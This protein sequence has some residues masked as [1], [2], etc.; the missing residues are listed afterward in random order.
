MNF[1]NNQ[2]VPMN[3]SG[4]WR[5]WGTNEPPQGGFGEAETPNPFAE[6]FQIAYRWK[7]FILAL[8]VLGAGVGFAWFLFTPQMYSATATLE[9]QGFNESFM[10]MNIV[11]PQAGTG[12][13]SPTVLNLQTQI[14]IL[15]SASLRR[16]VWERLERETAPMVVL[17]IGIFA[18]LRRLIGSDEKDPLQSMR[19]GLELASFNFNAR[20]VP[21]TR[22]IALNTESTNPEIAANFV[23]TLANE[24]MSQNIQFRASNAQ[25]T[26]QW[27]AGQ[28][29]ETKYRLEQAEAKLQ[30]FIRTSGLVFV[31]DQNT[32][33]DS[34]LR[35]LQGE[36]SS[37][38]SD[39]IEKQTR[40]ELL[41]N[42]PADSLPD[43][44]DDVNL[45]NAQQE[46]ARLK[47]ERQVLLT[48]LTPAHRKV[49]LL[50]AEIAA[51]EPTVRKERED[52]LRR[53]RS[54][55]EAAE[56]REKLLYNAY[57]A[58]ARAL[59]AQQDKAAQYNLLKREVENLRQSLAT[60]LQQANQASVVSAV[61]TTNVRLVDAAGPARL[62]SRPNPI[63]YTGAG[64]GGGVALAY[65]V[66][67]LVVKLRQARRQKKLMSPGH[68][69]A[70]LRVPE[71]GVIP[72]A[73]PEE[74]VRRFRRLPFR[75]SAA[76]ERVEMFPGYA[77]SSM[78]AES[79]RLVLTSLTLM[80]QRGKPRNVVV[81]TSSVPGE[82]KTTVAANVG[83][84]MAESGK[85][86]LVV[87]AD[88]RRP[89][90][91]ETFGVANEFGF[92]DLITNLGPVPQ[93]LLAKALRQTEY[94]GLWVMPGGDASDKVV[95]HLFGGAE[96]PF[97][98]EQLRNQFDT[99]LID[100]PPML[101]FSEARL[102]GRLADGVI[103]VVR[104]GSTDR[105]TA[106]AAR[107]RLSEDG[108][109]LI[110]VILNDWLPADKEGGAYYHSYYRRYH[111][112]AA[113]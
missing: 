35:Q 75:R 16:P 64:V 76:R 98:L 56:A 78:M 106:L 32:L 22:I 81:I 52:A 31:S 83:R 92:G 59:S 105:E 61:Q 36:L 7:W 97:L 3:P 15:E 42:S 20:I 13:Y 18:R 54:E 91:H 27:L 88:L 80:A 111:S 19:T 109:S 40:Y 26:T 11:D 68:A 1:E 67:L 93:E 86:V 77:R 29:E 100:T 41:K 37:I 21:G 57:T 113:K 82:G 79:F 89:R 55:Y 73:V 70:L 9:L 84:V 4:D 46:L 44:F 63:K 30:E 39:R 112:G 99:I 47:R 107:Q 101:H 23:N 95:N 50:D 17:P 74:P 10:G 49:Q 24:Y 72:S 5:A 62:P 14:R 87:D 90:L 96:I 28:V 33:T 104:A 38:Q 103:L 48:T 53:I 58:Q 2:L 69:A 94:E 60:M 85:K 6:Y 8:A 66:A 108:I 25:K 71:L 45:R 102:M 43:V 110:G 51:V 65:G 12:N 34:K